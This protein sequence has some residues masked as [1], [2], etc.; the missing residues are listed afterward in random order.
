M[1]TATE[2]YLHVMREGFILYE[3]KMVVVSHV[4]R[5]VGTIV[6]IVNSKK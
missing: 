4:V 3:H 2:R 5:P 1:Q 6:A